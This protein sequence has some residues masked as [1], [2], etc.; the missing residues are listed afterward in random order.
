MRRLYQ[1]LLNDARFHQ[2]L[3]EFDHDLAAM[4]RDGGCAECGGRLHSAVFPRKPR[5]VP[6]GLGEAYCRRFSF[7]CAVDGC[8][9]RSTPASLR[10]LGRKVWLATVVTLVTV[11]Q[12]GMTAARERRLLNELGISRRTLARWRRWWLTVF[13]GPFRPLAMASFMPPLDLAGVPA[14]L[15]DR[16]VGELSERL[17]HLLR[18]LASLSGGATAMRAL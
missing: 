10:F 8:R 17:V 18:F 1:A 2:Q 4:A 12:Q 6:P 3:L 14:T 11:M 16:F 7:C 15:L 9:T 5:G 13:A